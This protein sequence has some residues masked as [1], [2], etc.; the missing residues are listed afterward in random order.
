MLIDV[1]IFMAQSTAAA[2]SAFLGIELTFPR[3]ADSP[4]RR[5]QIRIAFISLALVTIGLGSWQQFRNVHSAARTNATIEQT[6]TTVTDVKT[7]VADVKTGVADVKTRVDGMTQSLQTIVKVVGTG[8]GGDRAL[9]P[10]PA[11]NRS[12]TPIITT[13]DFKTAPATDGMT[14]E[15]IRDTYAFWPVVSPPSSALTTV[16]VWDFGDGSA[17]RCASATETQ[18]HYYHD[19]EKHN[20]KLRSFKFR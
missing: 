4:R 16:V 19:G 8:P 18:T 5:L 3:T 12:I 11:R 9:T 15:I 6:K 10:G 2:V 14:G 17:L 7:T 13:V 20:V 1:A